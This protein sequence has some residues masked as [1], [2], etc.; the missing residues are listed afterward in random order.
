M[1]RPIRLRQ[2]TNTFLDQGSYLAKT[3]RKPD[4][5]NYPGRD[6]YTHCLIVAKVAQALLNRLPDWLVK[7]YFPEGSALVAGCHD[8]GKISPTFQYKIYKNLTE[9]QVELLQIIENATLD[10]NNLWGGHAGVSQVTAEFLNVGKYIPEILGKHHGFSPNLGGRN[11]NAEVFGG[12]AWLNLREKLV[13]KLKFNLQQKFPL[14]KSHIHAQLLAGLTTVSDWIGSGRFFENPNEEWQSKIEQSLDL[15]GFIRPEF[16]LQLTFEQIFGFNQFPVQTKLFEVANEAGVYI[17]EA[18]MGLG[19]TEAAL[20]VAYKFLSQNN[21]SGI[22]FALPTQLTSEKIHERVAVFL[23]VVLT[24]ESLHAN[25]ILLHSNAWLKQVEMGEEACPGGAWFSQGKR[26]ILAPF[27]VGT[28]DQV[29]MAVM[30]VRHGFVRIFGLAGK[31]VI[32]DEVHTYDAFTGTLLDELVCTLRQLHCTVI[33]LSAT[34]TQERRAKLIGADINSIAYPLI[35]WVTSQEKK[36]TEVPVVAG[37][38]KKV[39]VQIVL[40][41]MI[42]FEEALKRAEQGQQILWIENTVAEA[43]EAFHKFGARALGLGVQTG[44]LHSRFTQEH[45]QKNEQ[46]WVNAY[47]KA[48]QATRAK[49]GRILVGT[50]VLEQ[51]LDIDAD[52]LVTRLAPTDMLLQRLGRLWR[53]DNPNRN[54]LAQ[55]DVWILAHDLNEAIIHPE[56]IF[57]A[58]SKVYAPYVLCRTLEVWGKRTQITL[59]Q[60]IRALIE[61]TYQKREE[62][63]YMAKHLN[64]VENER[65]K[66]SAHALMDLSTI[67]QTKPDKHV[68]TRFSEQEIIEVLLFKR[69][70]LNQTHQN[71]LGTWLTLLSDELVFLPHNGRAFGHNIWREL[72]A[73]LAQNTIK[74]AEYIAPKSMTKSQLNWLKDYFYLGDQNSGDQNSLLRV[75]LVDADDLVKTLDSYS[76]V[77]ETYQISYNEYNGYKAIKNKKE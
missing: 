11:A 64:V 58:S 21:A 14:V 65:R 16:R 49:Y 26:G 25:P 5:S 50:Q 70:N 18:P 40:D 73:K 66:L 46:E 1:K 45:R 7:I 67:S 32:L 44:L 61:A 22:Y 59:P 10:E 71:I 48:G 75:G 19:K 60:D 23:K 53:H 37:S 17:L 20:Y 47:G 54:P 6:V 51:S 77:N 2:N 12:V 76:E 31:V 3:W 39:T 62:S 63:E 30:N 13:D 27:A 72:A 69:L 15:A 42:A 52:F 29:L 57:G 24:P 9:V 35:T 33:I 8:I 43:Q 34:L 36:V 41:N 55:Q 74:V 28:I 38:S 56:K 4:G 68:A